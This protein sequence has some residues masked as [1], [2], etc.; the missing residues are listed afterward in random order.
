[1]RT[2]SLFIFLST[3]L[4]FFSCSKDASDLE[5]NQIDT[6]IT[7]RA[8][9]SGCKNF[10]RNSDFSDNQING[11]LSN[12]CLD[13]MNVVTSWSTAS[14]TPYVAIP[15]CF[16]C[17]PS[18]QGWTDHLD[19]ES[20]FAGS[21]AVQQ[22]LSFPNDPDMSYWL[23]F[24]AAYSTTPTSILFQIGTNNIQ[25][26]I[27]NKYE[28]GCGNSLNNYTSKCFKPTL[29]N[30]I[31]VTLAG[32]GN[33]HLDNI[34]MF[35]K[36]DFLTGIEAIQNQG[37]SFDFRP[38]LSGQLNVVEYNWDFGDG[39]T[40]NLENPNHVFGPGTF[41]VTLT[42]TDDRGCCT[43]VETSVSCQDDTCIYYLCWAQEIQAVDYF[44]GFTVDGVYHQFDNQYYIVGNY[45]EIVA[46]ML[47]K[48]DN[49]FQGAIDYGTF[50]A[51]HVD[52]A[53]FKQSPIH[54]IPGFFFVDSPSEIESF[55]TDIGDVPFHQVDC[56]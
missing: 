34:Q 27:V 21:D 12:D 54:D 48:M 47:S 3:I 55:R 42:I 28:N 8:G 45:D 18:Q 14:G 9:N 1:M 17:P 13:N 4:F 51:D 26:L 50:M 37:C 46:E 40:S 41:T 7:T 16:G 32:T 23:C 44:Y 15:D 39:E 49:Y 6:V 29:A 19:L 52:Y 31:H 20:G 56:N 33:L 43:T 2:Q 24:D 35:C 11:G 5:V 38:Q 25:Q 36:S 22:A 30:G 10:I 53:C